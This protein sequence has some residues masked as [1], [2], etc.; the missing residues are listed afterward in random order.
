MLSPP[1]GARRRVDD[2]EYGPDATRILAE[3]PAAAAGYG[4]MRDGTSRRRCPTAAE[5]E[6]VVASRERRQ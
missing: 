5:R 3:M 2:R 1:E 4:T 6:H